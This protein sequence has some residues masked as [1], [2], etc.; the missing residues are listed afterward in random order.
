MTKIERLH[1]Q[2]NLFIEANTRWSA[3][4]WVINNNFS[5]MVS[6]E[7]RNIISGGLMAAQINLHM[8]TDHNIISICTMEFEI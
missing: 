7:Y 8:K 5:G 1:G 2:T 6:S 3:Y 4:L